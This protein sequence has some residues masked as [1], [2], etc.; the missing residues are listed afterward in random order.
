MYFVYTYRHCGS[1]PFGTM[2]IIILPFAGSAVAL[3]NKEDKNDFF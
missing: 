1:I 3:F 2:F